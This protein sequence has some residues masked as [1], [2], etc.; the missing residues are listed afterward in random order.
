MLRDQQDIFAS[1]WH[2]FESRSRCFLPFEK[3]QHFRQYDFLLSAVLCVS[4]L[5]LSFSSYHE[6]SHDYGM[7]ANIEVRSITISWNIPIMDLD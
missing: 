2:D 7:P 1:L 4:P 3:L 5:R 6:V